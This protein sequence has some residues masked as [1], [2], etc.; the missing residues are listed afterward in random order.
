MEYR[1]QQSLSSTSGPTEVT[2]HHQYKTDGIEESKLSPS[3]FH[4]FS[5]W[6][7]EAQASTQV[8]EPEAM[9][10]GT[11]KVINGTARPSSRV[12]LLKRF[13]HSGFVFY[14]NYTSRK[15][16]EM[17]S[18]PWASLTFYW[19]AMHRSVRIS[20]RVEKLSQEDT[21]R[22][23]NSRPLGSRVGAI[24]SPQSQTIAHRQ[25]LED[26]VRSVEQQLDIPGAA[27]LDGEAKSYS[28]DTQISPPT[29]W[30]GY[31]VVPYEMEFWMG[32]ANRLH[33]RFRYAP[34]FVLIMANPSQIYP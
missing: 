4:Q 15:G 19:Y 1:S 6:F 18:N 20:G 17:E 3:A 22:Y 26:K 7:R 16:G 34:L 25:E 9:V 24:A 32:R 27:G 31:L 2:T 14:S 10:L 11:A 28:H 12:V 30:G 23:F 29:Y 13:D 33:D 5:T 21:A 8:P